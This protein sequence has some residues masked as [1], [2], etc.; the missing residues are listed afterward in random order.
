MDQVEVAGAAVDVSMPRPP[1]TSSNSPGRRDVVVAEVADHLVAIAGAAVGGVVAAAAVQ[2]VGAGAAAD[3]VA[4]EAGMDAVVA[5]AG[6]DHVA[7]RGV[8]RMLS[9]PS[10]PT[11]VADPPTAAL[12]L[13]L[14]RRSGS[15]RDEGAS[16]PRRQHDSPAEPVHE[17]GW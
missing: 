6:P 3:Q 14:R 5:A 2:Q 16:A 7:A 12:L 15:H 1:A 8:P 9:A 11:N 13:V 17:W 10:V 4:A